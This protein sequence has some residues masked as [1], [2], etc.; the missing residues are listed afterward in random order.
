MEGEEIA[1]QPAFDVS[2]GF[3]SPRLGSLC[4]APAER[5]G[6]AAGRRRPFRE[7]CLSEPRDQVPGVTLGAVCLS[8]IFA[9][10]VALVRCSAG[11]T[12]C[13]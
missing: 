5:C 6:A 2:R 12:G 7:L 1:L 8:S 3:G 4:S 10:I 9:F 11:V 13:A